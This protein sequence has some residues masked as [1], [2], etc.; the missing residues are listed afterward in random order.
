MSGENISA[1]VDYALMKNFKKAMT[2][3]GERTREFPQRW[4]VTVD[5]GGLYHYT[6]PEKT[7]RFKSVIEGLGNKDWLAAWMEH[8]AG[9][10]KHYRRG[11]PID[12]MRMAVNDG[13]A[14]GGRPFNYQDEITVPVS[15]WFGDPG[16]N[17]ELVDGY[18]TGCLE[19]SIALTQGESAPYVYLLHTTLPTFDDEGKKI[20]TSAPFH[21]ASYGGA[22]QVVIA[23]AS[24]YVDGSRLRPGQVI[25]GIPATE[26]CSNGASVYIKRVWTLPDKFLTKLPNGKTFGEQALTP[27]GSAVPAVVALQDAEVDIFAMGPITG[28]GVAKAIAITKLNLTL[29]ITQWPFAMPLTCQFVQEKFVISMEEMLNTFNCGILFVI[30]VQRSDVQRAQDA[31][32]AVGVELPEI[33]VVEDGPRQTIFGPEN[34]LVLP[35]PGD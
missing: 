12:A 34:N 28:G 2:A 7:H 1:G 4:G 29:R 11:I 26:W 14:I 32:A 10:G 6:G 3:L 23:P 18:F 20:V 13:L 35:E 22:V 8:Y 33:G 19:D 5:P 16:R 9:D 25:L 21:A 31:A 30:C 15:G 24:R 27:T 17:A